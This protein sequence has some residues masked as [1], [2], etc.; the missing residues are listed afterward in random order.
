[1]SNKENLITVNP[2]VKEKGFKN[3]NIK[4]EEL[5]NDCNAVQKRINGL[6]NTQYYNEL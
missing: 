6:L 5:T 3:K 4:I 1:M 2:T